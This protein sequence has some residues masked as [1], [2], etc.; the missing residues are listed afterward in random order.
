MKRC[1]REG[2]WDG[3]RENTSQ[4]NWHSTDKDGGIVCDGSDPPRTFELRKVKN[5]SK[6]YLANDRPTQIASYSIP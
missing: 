1:C 2:Y 5:Y 4:L 3:E 6:N